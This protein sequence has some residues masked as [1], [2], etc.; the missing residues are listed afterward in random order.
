MSKIKIAFIYDF[1]K[2]LSPKDM[3]EYSFLPDIN[4]EPKQ[5]WAEVGKESKMQKADN[6][7]TYMQLMIEKAKANGKENELT[8]VALKNK[9]KNIE[10]FNGVEGWFDLINDYAKELGAV[11]EHYIISAGNKE[12]LEGTSIAKNFKKI[13]GCSFRFDNNDVAKSAGLA[14]NYTNKTQFIF[15]INKGLLD[16]WDNSKI[17]DYVPDADRSFPFENMVYFG[18]GD[19]DIPCMKLV[20]EK[21]GYSIAVYKPNSSKKKVEKLLRDGR[22]N[23]F[24]PADYSENK[25]IFKFCKL[26]ID[27]MVSQ[28]KL[29]LEEKKQSLKVDPLKSTEK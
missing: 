5:F 22:V 20:K 24:Y 13:Y 17:N 4:M 11:I 28:N 18:D 16:E 9:G 2:T 23:F 14:I 8:K 25:E 7:I 29:K 15:R 6:I 12:I 26:I 19:T 10:L 21:G 1:D 3:Q 27:K